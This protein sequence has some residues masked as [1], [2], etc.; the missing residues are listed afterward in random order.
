MAFLLTML[1]ISITACYFIDKLFEHFVEM[2][3]KS[4]HASEEK[5][6][7]EIQMYGIKKLF[8]LQRRKGTPRYECMESKN[9]NASE[10]KRNTGIKMEGI[11]IV[12]VYITY[13]FVCAICS[14]II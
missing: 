14:F 5:R 10:E 3:D 2:K 6:N 8:T 4:A 1:L 13:A 7:T 12:K 9:T 11:A